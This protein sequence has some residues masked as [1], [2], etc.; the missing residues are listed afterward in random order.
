MVQWDLEKEIWAR[1]FKSASLS[2]K[3]SWD[4]SSTG[5]LV[6]EPVFNFP[7]VQAA[8]EE[9]RNAGGVAGRQ[10]TRSGPPAGGVGLGWRQRAGWR[11]TACNWGLAGGGLPTSRQPSIC[12][13]LRSW[14]LFHEERPLLWFTIFTSLRFT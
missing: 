6:T 11:G 9:V 14:F 10:V 2:P 4:P 3:G 1:A 12:V 8:T 5:L 7:A 13:R